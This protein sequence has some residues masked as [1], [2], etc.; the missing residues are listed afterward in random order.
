MEI[1]AYIAY[2]NPDLPLTFWRT[3]TG[4]EVDFILG[5]KDLAIEIKGSSRVHHKD[6]SSLLALME[7]GQV[8]KSC[9]VCLEEEPSFIHKNIEILP[10]KMFL[11]KL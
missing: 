2:K 11:E 1:Q 5:E 4:R 6:A 9:I 10:W 8:K 3:S 7:D